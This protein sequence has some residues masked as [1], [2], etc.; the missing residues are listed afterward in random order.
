MAET[1]VD[2]VVEFGEK[3]IFPAGD[4][5]SPISNISHLG[6]SLNGGHYV[7][8]TKSVS[9]QWWLLDDAKSNKVPFE[10]VTNSSSYIILLKKDKPNSIDNLQNEKR[11]SKV[12]S[13][14]DKADKVQKRAMSG[15][16]LSL[17][18]QVLEPKDQNLRT[19]RKRHTVVD[20]VSQKRKKC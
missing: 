5:Y 10:Q 9:G 6:Q 14:P 2:T 20:Y 17:K 8:F 1:K 12:C 16:E 15:Q 11:D 7:N 18:S 3:V 19:E 4:T 13:I